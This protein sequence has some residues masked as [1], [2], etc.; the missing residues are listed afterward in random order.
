MGFD[1]YRKC[2]FEND[3]IYGIGIE[4]KINEN[5]Y[6]GNFSKYS[7]YGYLTI[8]FIYFLFIRRI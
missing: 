6:Y 3:T 5:L 8:P 2:G 1:Q 4:Q 7:P